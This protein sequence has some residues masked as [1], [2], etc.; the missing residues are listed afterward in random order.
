MADSKTIGLIGVTAV[1]LCIG[2]Y[3]IL[4]S[5]DTNKP[6]TKSKPKKNVNDVVHY[7]S[8]DETLKGYKKNSA[9]KTTTYF[10]RELSEKDKMLL[11][12]Q[13]PKRIDIN[14]ETKQT[15][16]PQKISPNSTNKAGDGNKTQT[17]STW[18]QAGTWEE[19]NLTK[20]GLDRIRKLLTKYEK[21][22]RNMNHDV[23]IRFTN[24]KALSG[25]IYITHTRGKK[26][27]LYDITMDV[28]FK[29]IITSINGDGFK[30]D[31]IVTGDIKVTDFSPDDEI[32][33]VSQV[34]VDVV[35]VV[36]YMYLYDNC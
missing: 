32:F 19:K 7:S 3:V 21:S 26:L 25:E 6:T 35:G 4:S 29:I 15:F 22:Y 10:N 36:L 31:T 9:G 8:D 24:V 34:C 18:N 23:C 33:E 12:D 2:A 5:F 11:G 1:A 16:S 14:N 30:H 13:T 27:Y 20:W 17:V 28:S